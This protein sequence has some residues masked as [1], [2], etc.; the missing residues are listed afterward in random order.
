VVKQFDK[1]DVIDISEMCASAIYRSLTGE[2][3]SELIN[4]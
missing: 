1:I 2:S 4:L 3:I